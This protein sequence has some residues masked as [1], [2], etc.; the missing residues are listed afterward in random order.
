MKSNCVDK[1]L[2]IACNADVDGGGF[3]DYIS[4]KMSQDTVSCDDNLIGTIQAGCSRSAV[5]ASA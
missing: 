1:A 4:S 5:R 2:F 3:S